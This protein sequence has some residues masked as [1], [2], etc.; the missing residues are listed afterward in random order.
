M[1]SACSKHGQLVKLSVFHARWP[2][3]V[4]EL[5]KSLAV[6]IIKNYCLR[7]KLLQLFYFRCPGNITN[8]WQLGRRRA[9][10]LRFGLVGQTNF[11]LYKNHISVLSTEYTY[12]CVN[13]RYMYVWILSYPFKWDV[14]DCNWGFG[15]LFW[16]SPH[17][18]VKPDYYT[19]DNFLFH[20][21]S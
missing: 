9:V 20:A 7:S 11:F 14:Q 2:G 15:S 16:N 21:T 19:D 4:L 6:T 8:S 18:L 3:L 13:D 12:K 17:L 10:Q 1:S 5:P